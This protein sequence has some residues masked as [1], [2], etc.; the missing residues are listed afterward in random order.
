MPETVASDTFNPDTFKESRP[1]L[2]VLSWKVFL[3]S[4]EPVAK[5]ISGGVKFSPVMSFWGGALATTP[6][7]VADEVD[8]GRTSF[9][10]M[11]EDGEASFDSNYATR[12]DKEAILASKELVFWDWYLVSREEEVLA[13]LADSVASPNIPDTIYDILFP[14]LP[15]PT[16]RFEILSSRF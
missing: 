14:L 9:A 8:S 15:I 7:S 12:A 2:K 10:R 1:T 4:A 3:S 13:S 6:E 16:L 11:T 5:S